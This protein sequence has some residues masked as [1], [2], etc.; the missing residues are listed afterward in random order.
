VAEENEL[1]DLFAEE[2]SRGTKRPRRAKQIEKDRLIHQGVARAIRQRDV[3]P[4]L[5]A[6]RKAG[7]NDDSP[8]F[9]RA[10]RAFEKAVAGSR[11]E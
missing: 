7:W 8:E 11:Q 5:D 6:L 2:Q 1:S 3:R 10:V 9:A 4:L